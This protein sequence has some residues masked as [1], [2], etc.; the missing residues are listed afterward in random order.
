VHS[1]Q[2][3]IGADEFHGVEPDVDEAVSVRA[4]RCEARVNDDLVIA[5]AALVAQEVD[6][7]PGRAI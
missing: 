3:W 5:A 7:M 4:H 6:E 2:V 1:L